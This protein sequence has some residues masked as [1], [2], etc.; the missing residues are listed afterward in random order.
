MRFDRT[1]IVCLA[2]VV[3]HFA[4]VAYFYADL[5]DPVPSHW[6]AQGEV[7]GFT[8][9]PWGA[10]LLPFF[11]LGIYLLFKVIPWISPKGFR[12][13]SFIKIV[14]ILKQTLVFF[15]FII[16]ATVIFAAKGADFGPGEI[17]LPGIGVLFIILGNYMGKLRKNFFIGIRT[18][19]TLANDEVWTK[20]HRLGGWTFVLAGLVMI[21][22]GL[23]GWPPMNFTIIAVVSLAA[24]VPVVYSFVIYKRLEGFGPDEEESGS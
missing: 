11:T 2:V 20:T 7:D 21:I 9:K 18:P 12:M 14:G 10:W 23:T 19:W 16:G 15:M 6:N 17:I 3:L 4:L 24:L 1:D 5:P 8:P 22:T 13:E